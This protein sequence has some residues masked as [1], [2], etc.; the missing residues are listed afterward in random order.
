[1]DK[2]NS[3][4]I[5]HKHKMLLFVKQP[6]RKAPIEQ[7]E[8]FFDTYRKLKSNR[9]RILASKIGTNFLVL[10]QWPLRAMII[11]VLYSII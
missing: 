6:C 7:Y 9:L 8:G 3:K 5:V 4:I 2:F 10:R 1:M 11:V